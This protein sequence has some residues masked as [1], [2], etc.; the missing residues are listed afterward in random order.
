MEQGFDRAFAPHEGRRL[1]DE[2]RVGSFHE[3]AL[4]VGRDEVATL[5]YTS[6]TTGDP[7]GVM[8]TPAGARAVRIVIATIVIISGPMSR[9]GPPGHILEPFLNDAQLAL[10]RRKP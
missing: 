1:V 9:G 8:L 10:R 3:R 7:K 6:G 4:A 5:I 2:G